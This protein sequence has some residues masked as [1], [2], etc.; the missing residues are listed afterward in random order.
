MTGLTQ[1]NCFHLK[2]AWMVAAALGLALALA[3]ASA[4][5][6]AEPGPCKGPNKNDPGCGGSETGVPALLTLGLPLDPITGEPTGAMSTTD[7][8]V[9]VTQDSG[10]RLQFQDTSFELPGIQVHLGE[11]LNSGN[12]GIDPEFQG[13]A[14]APS[15][16][17]LLAELNNA[18]IPAGYLIV[19]IDKKKREV[20]FV[21]EY[22]VPEDSPG[23]ELPD[24]RIRIFFF[25]FGRDNDPAKV[26]G[27]TVDF[28]GTDLTISGSIAI[29]WEDV[30]DLNGSIILVCDG[31][32]VTVKLD[33]VP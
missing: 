13:D 25:D 6:F 29:W 24:G 4:P 22:F 21:I 28:P 12:C 26:V 30:P 23:S 18:E 11:L 17:E 16:E 8:P 10:K 20:E 3:V 27:G 14:N 19:R 15:D 1:M 32:E 7:L 31:Q 9:R 33:S 5:A 2:G